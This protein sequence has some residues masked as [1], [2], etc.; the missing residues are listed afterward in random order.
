MRPEASSLE[1]RLHLLKYRTF[2][3]IGAGFYSF[4]TSRK[5][6]HYNLARA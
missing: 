1:S 5:A 6:H 2:E 3:E 4:G